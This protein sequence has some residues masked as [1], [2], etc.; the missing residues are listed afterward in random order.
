MATELKPPII[1]F[2]NTRSGTTIV[3]DVISAHPGVVS[4]YEP[5]EL[6]LYA[7]PSRPHDEFEAHDATE[8]AKRYIRKRFLQYQEQN[9]G[10]RV[11]EKTPKNIFKIPYVH[12]IFPEAAYL[13]I[14]RN[15]FSFISS[16]EMKWQKTVTGKGIMR[17]LKSTPVLQIHHHLF[18]YL[19]QQYNKRIR[20]RKYL[21][22]WG[23][24]YRGIQDDVKNCD[25]LTVIARQWAYGSRKAEQDIAQLGPGRVLKLRYEDFVDDPLPYV[26]QI[27][28]HCGVEMTA[29]IVK[30]A[31][32]MVKADRKL[33]WQRFQPDDLA[34]I[35]PEIEGEMARHG[36]SIP[37]EIREAIASQPERQNVLAVNSG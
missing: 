15:P 28:A 37:Q 9:N 1:L 4:W 17:R 6:W 14:V 30:A 23:P 22:I 26:E 18:N 34:R 3:Q 13:Y 27:C 24:R 5:S 10:A 31:N 36:Y 21:S 2:G 25:L 29:E 12:A 8:R 7:D 32:E 33:K 11:F 35:L 20:K 16:V 19:M